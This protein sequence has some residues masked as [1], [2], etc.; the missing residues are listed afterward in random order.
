MNLFC[1]TKLWLGTTLPTFCGIGLQMMQCDI[2]G[3]LISM[4]ELSLIAKDPNK[5]S[6]YCSVS[7]YEFELQQLQDATHH[8]LQGHYHIEGGHF[9]HLIT[10]LFNFCSTHKYLHQHRQHLQEPYFVLLYHGNFST[11][12]SREMIKKLKINNRLKINVNRFKRNDSKF[13]RNDLLAGLTKS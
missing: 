3:F 8:H 6:F 10:W 11:T 4:G 12:N 13:K 2:C 9:Q 5:L 7:I 1:K